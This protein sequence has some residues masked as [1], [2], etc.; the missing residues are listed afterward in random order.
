MELIWRHIFRPNKGYKS[1]RGYNDG[2]AETFSILPAIER[3]G[4]RLATRDRATEFRR[5]DNG[6]SA[7]ADGTRRATRFR[8]R[9]RRLE[10]APVPPPAALNRFHDVGRI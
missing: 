6:P 8:L 5:V 3:P 10:D 4:R 1:S 7:C 9:D 2:C